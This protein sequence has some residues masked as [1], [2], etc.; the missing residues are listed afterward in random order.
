MTPYVQ[1]MMTAAF[2]PAAAGV[3]IM[4]RAGALMTQQMV[5]M[6][7]MTRGDTSPDFIPDASKMIPAPS[8]IPGT[9][10]QTTSSSP[11]PV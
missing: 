7:S 1:R 9:A 5:D 11:M 6:M 10:M 3:E 4:A 8:D 2:Y